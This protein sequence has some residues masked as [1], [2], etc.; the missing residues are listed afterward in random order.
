MTVTLS[1]TYPSAA[2]RPGSRSGKNPQRKWS[3][4]K[5]CVRIRPPAF[6][7]SRIYFGGNWVPANVVAPKPLAAVGIRSAIR[8]ALVSRVRRTIF[9][10]G[11]LFILIEPSKAPGWSFKY[12]V[13]GREKLI[14]FGVYPKA[15]MA[16]AR[17]RRADAAASSAMVA[18]RGLAVDPRYFARQ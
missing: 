9:D 8:Q 16:I 13:S 18:S 4:R 2:V 1:A 3:F 5:S 14:S 12:R 15:S 17:E 7:H 11:G 10:S 6:A